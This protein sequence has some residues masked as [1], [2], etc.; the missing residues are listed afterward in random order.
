MSSRCPRTQQTPPK[1]SLTAV[2]Y[3]VRLKRSLL[4][5][6]TQCFSPHS[7]SHPSSR[8]LV[9]PLRLAPRSPNLVP[10]NDLRLLRRR[11][12]QQHPPRLHTTTGPGHEAPFLRLLRHPALLLVRVAAE[13]GRLHLAHA[14]LAGRQRPARP[15]R[16]GAPPA[17]GAG[18]CRDARR[19]CRAGPRA[20]E[21]ARPRD[22]GPAVVRVD[23]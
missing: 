2:T 9:P 17:G 3:I 21:C 7:P 10:L 23:D 5:P 19:C 18:R 22:A 1:S 11:N 14:R 15:G 16:A 20:G 8:P 4:L 12:P 6:S 13:R